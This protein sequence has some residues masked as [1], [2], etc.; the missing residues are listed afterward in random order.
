MGVWVVLLYTVL[1]F[2]GPTQVQFC[3][4]YLLL[5]WDAR[6]HS[7]SDNTHFIKRS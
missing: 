2:S 1:V 4:Y 7:G 6:I 3:V 5:Q